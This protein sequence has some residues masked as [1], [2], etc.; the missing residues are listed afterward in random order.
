MRRAAIAPGTIVLSVIRPEIC[1]SLVGQAGLVVA[2]LGKLVRGIRNLSPR[3]CPFDHAPVRTAA[4]REPGFYLQPAVTVAAAATRHAVPRPDA[5]ADVAARLC[6]LRGGASRMGN[7]ARS[8]GR[9]A[10]ANADRAV[11]SG[12]GNLRGGP[13]RRDLGSDPDS[14]LRANQ[15]PKSQL[16]PSYPVILSVWDFRRAICFWPT[17]E[18]RGGPRRKQER[19]RRTRGTLRRRYTRCPP[20][21]P[22]PSAASSG[23][24]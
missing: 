14:E 3:I 2:V 12:T 20:H 16:V 7:F 10:R 19:R 23:R 5:A 1:K 22:A 18:S 21:A 17:R 4:C 24:S 15:G 6:C 8:C 9:R 13:G 11:L